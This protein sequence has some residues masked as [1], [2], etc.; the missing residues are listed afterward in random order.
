MINNILDQA[1]L[2]IELFEIIIG[3]EVLSISSGKNSL[4]Y[5]EENYF[6][7]WGSHADY[8]LTKCKQLNDDGG[9]SGKCLTSRQIN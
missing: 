5:Q 1:I 7:D 2:N 9:F 4:E 8:Y 3:I 6:K